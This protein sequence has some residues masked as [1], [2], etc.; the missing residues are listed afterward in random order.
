M[1]VVEYVNIVFRQRLSNSVLNTSCIQ[2]SAI[3]KLV[4]PV[5]WCALCIDAIKFHLGTTYEMLILCV[6][7]LLVL[8][9]KHVSYMELQY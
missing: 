9:L 1:Y 6:K 7:S 5:S 8:L 3:L 4:I 2:L